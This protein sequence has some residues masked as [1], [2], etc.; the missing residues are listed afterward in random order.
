MADKGKKTVKRQKNG[1]PQV[2]NGYLMIANELMEATLKI[3]MNDYERRVWFAV[4]R[5]TYGWNK[6]ESPISLSEISKLTGLQKGHVS[7]AIKSLIKRNMLYSKESSKNRI[8]GLVKHYKKWIDLPKGSS[9]GTPKGSSPGT[10]KENFTYSAND[11]QEAPRGSLSGTPKSSSSG[12]PRSSSGTPWSSSLGTQNKENP[13]SGEVSQD[14]SKG[15]SSGTL[16]EDGGSSSGTQHKKSSNEVGGSYS[17]T[18]AQEPLTGVNPL[19][20]NESRDPKY[21]TKKDNI[22]PDKLDNQVKLDTGVVPPSLGNSGFKSVN[23]ILLSNLSGT[24]RFKNR[25]STRSDPTTSEIRKPKKPNS[26]TK[27]FLSAFDELFKK[28]T[29]AS[30]SWTDY[31]AELLQ[32]RLKKYGEDAAKAALQIFFEDWQREK[33]IFEG[34][35]F[36]PSLRLFLSIS[37]LWTAAQKKLE[38]SAA[39]F[40]T[41]SAAPPESSSSSGADINAQSG[42]GAGR[43]DHPPKMTDSIG[44]KPA[45]DEP[46]TSGVQLHPKNLS[47]KKDT[48]SP[49]KNTRGEEKEG[50][51]SK[52]PNNT[53]LPANLP[54]D[55]KG[56]PSRSEQKEKLRGKKKAEKSKKTVK[57]EKKARSPTVKKETLLERAQKYV[58]NQVLKK[59]YPEVYSRRYGAEPIVAFSK[60]GKGV[61]NITKYL[62]NS[63]CRK[64]DVQEKEKLKKI[65]KEVLLEWR[66]LLEEYMEDDDEWIERANYSLTFLQKRINSYLTWLGTRWKKRREKLCADL[67]KL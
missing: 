62:F 6:K 65:T 33:R 3:K 55:E 66:E 46:Q 49:P 53:T 57:S 20:H 50:G 10:P 32:E 5:L 23:D 52:I 41:D 54:L 21:I 8:I 48:S 59:I 28:F 2:E 24:T 12:T 40:E 17:G 13:Y 30:A 51:S 45:P 36:K 1:N 14:L 16:N 11:S 58:V 22:S 26:S 7:R 34:T 63:V 60:E 67:E 19:Q 15:S 29:G 43:K 37:S 31:D 38:K 39:F 35:G 64:K 61:Q 47:L 42:S 18:P 4:M 25:S 56:P 9:L 44:K 27:K